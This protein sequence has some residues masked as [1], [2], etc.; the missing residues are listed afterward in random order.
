MSEF[1]FDSNISESALRNYLS[2]SITLSFISNPVEPHGDDIRMVFDLGAKYIARSI[3][4]WKAETDYSQTI[5]DYAN[6]DG[7]MK[8]RLVLFGST[9]IKNVTKYDIILFTETFSC[10]RGNHEK[11][12]IF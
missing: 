6:Q 7:V 3:I 9:I 11:P 10:R 5:E 1:H 4:P 8:K 12:C 2:R